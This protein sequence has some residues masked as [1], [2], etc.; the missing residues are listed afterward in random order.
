M[1]RQSISGNLFSECVVI[2]EHQNESKQHGDGEWGRIAQIGKEN[3]VYQPRFTMILVYI[4]GAVVLLLLAA[5]F[6]GRYVM[7][8]FLLLLQ[9]SLIAL[10]LTG[11]TLR[12]EFSSIFRSS[13][14]EEDS[15]RR[16]DRLLLE[17]N[18][19]DLI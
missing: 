1:R 8:A 17:F 7:P 4:V 3:E 13:K 5:T 2:F 11:C 12:A 9:F 15:A 10:H 18:P 16:V 19:G 6:L 14:I